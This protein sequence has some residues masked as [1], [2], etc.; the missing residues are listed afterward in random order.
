MADDAHD[1][2]VRWRVRVE[3]RLERL[4]ELVGD[5]RETLHGVQQV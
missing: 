3:G 1:D 4:K 2:L 5:I